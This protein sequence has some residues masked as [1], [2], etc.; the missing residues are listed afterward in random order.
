[1]L[2]WTGDPGQV[3]GQGILLRSG[4]DVPVHIARPV[5]PGLH[6]VSYSAHPV[7]NLG[8]KTLE[9]FLAGDVAESGT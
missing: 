2:S 4:R 8:S 7:R 9:R 6:G 3:A 5:L 1:M